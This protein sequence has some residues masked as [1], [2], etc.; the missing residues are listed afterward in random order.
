MISTK[1]TRLAAERRA[2]MKT[3][4]KD[5][6]RYIKVHYFLTDLRLKW[7]NREITGQQ[8]STIRGQAL[9]GDLDGATKGLANV[10]LD[11]MSRRGEK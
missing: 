11:N 2:D 8:Y 10:I 6:T 7:K 5:A 4:Q 3:L 9:A 1:E